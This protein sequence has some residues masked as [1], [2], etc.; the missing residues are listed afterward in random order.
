MVKL[1]TKINF[2]LFPII[3]VIFIIAGIISYQSQKSLVLDSLKIK[4]EYESK[5]INETLENDYLELDSLMVRFLNS[6]EVARYLNG[7]NT[8]F[9]A[10]TLENQLLR[11]ISN[12]T[13]SSGRVISFSLMDNAG[14]NK[15]YFD[16]DDPFAEYKKNEVLD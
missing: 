15:F 4:L 9:S 2:I 11:Y 8:S 12:I 13:T 7:T 1:S 6:R 5:L 3:S 14:E 10:Y 16:M